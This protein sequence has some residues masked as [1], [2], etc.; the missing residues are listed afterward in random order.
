MVAGDDVVRTAAFTRPK[1]R[2]T[3]GLTAVRTT[4]TPAT[5]FP[6]DGGLLA[7]HAH[8]DDETLAT[9]ALL[10][11]WAAS[12][13]AVTVVTCTRGE[14]GEVIALP[15]TASAGLAHL[16]G[17]GPAL[18][19][20]RETELAAALRALGDGAIEHRFL[21]T[22]DA[23]AGPAGPADPDGRWE[24]SG[25]AWVAPGIAGP[26]PD[27][28]ASAFA[29]VPLDDAAARLAAVVR[30]RRPGVV[31]TYEAGGGYRHPDHVR[32]HEVTVRALALAADPTTA[33]G[34]EPWQVPELWEAM[35]AESRLR[36]ARRTLAAT[37]AVTDLAERAG[38]TFPDP[39]E[40]LPP[41]AM[42]DDQLSGAVEVS[43][44][45]VR[46][47]VLNALHAYA[48]QVQHVTELP[49]PVPL[50]GPTGGELLGCYALSNGVLAAVL[51]SETYRV[52]SGV[53]R[54]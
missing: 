43:V 18:G 9:G 46:R 13:R 48:T 33:L 36:G 5:T 2:S 53:P 45:R 35:V 15:G 52:R 24:D 47:R 31:V 27:A 49:A 54:G 20:Y 19:A 6:P 14:R 16:E 40:T 21:D 32:T 41:V 7:V 10:A 38:L 28:P 29:R 51:D 3:S 25:M 1:G 44:A 50:A 12:G 26:A 11:T 23:P 4:P 42:P 34:A 30:E 22:I 8:P 39:D 17:D 37:A